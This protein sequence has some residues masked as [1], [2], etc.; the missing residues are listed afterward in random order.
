[1]IFEIA[2]EGPEH[3]CYD[4]PL[5]SERAIFS[6]AIGTVNRKYNKFKTAFPARSSEGLFRCTNPLV[7]RDPATIPRAFI[8]NYR[9]LSNSS[10]LQT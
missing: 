4:V 6:S 2:Q 9:E 7:V 5:L 1:M 3:A 10:S 8:N